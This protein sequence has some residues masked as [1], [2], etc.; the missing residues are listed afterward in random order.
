MKKYYQ[1][2]QKDKAIYEQ[3]KT[4]HVQVTTNNYY[5]KSVNNTSPA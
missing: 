2:I 1:M 4:V 5:C 3:L